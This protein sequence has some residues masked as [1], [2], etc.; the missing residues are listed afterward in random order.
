MRKGQTVK[1]SPNPF[2]ESAEKL[3]GGDSIR[4]RADKNL[5]LIVFQNLLGNALKYRYP[6][7]RISLEV[8]KRPIS[9]SLFLEHERSGS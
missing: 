2:K 4:L 5:L 9:R 6:A 1:E 7:G 3:G 8:Q